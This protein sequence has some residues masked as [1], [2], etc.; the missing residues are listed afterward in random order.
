[1]LHHLE[2]SANYKEN[3]GCI[4]KVLTCGGIRNPGMNVQGLNFL[5]IHCVLYLDLFRTFLKF[6]VTHSFISGP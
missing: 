6:R 4:V 2:W 1:M 3:T 5:L